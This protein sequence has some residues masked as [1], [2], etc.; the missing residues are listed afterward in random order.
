MLVLYVLCATSHPPFI[1]PL[2]LKH[3]QL[4]L[5]RGIHPILLPP[6]CSIL[7]SQLLSLYLYLP[8]LYPP[9]LLI[10]LSQP[11]FHCHFPAV[12]TRRSR[13]SVC[14]CVYTEDGLLLRCR[15][16]T[17]GTSQAGNRIPLFTRTT[18]LFVGVG[19]GA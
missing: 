12:L 10:L 15:W 17:R 5:G 13:L 19:T 18:E 11:P 1:P 3:S 6:F 4:V 8:L 9:F 7:L 2:S 14:G 16:Q